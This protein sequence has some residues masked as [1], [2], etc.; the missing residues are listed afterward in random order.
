MCVDARGEP[1]YRRRMARR[2]KR[3][4]RRWLLLGLGLLAAAGALLM[5][6]GRGSDSPLAEIDAASRMKLERVLEQAE[7]EGVR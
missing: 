1:P 2:S 5:L 6:V 3:R 7:T 4:P